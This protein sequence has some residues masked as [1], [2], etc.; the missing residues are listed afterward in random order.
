M[1]RASLL[2]SLVRHALPCAVRVYGNQGTASRTKKQLEAELAA[3]G[4]QLT[5]TT[6]RE[7]I[8]FQAQVF[9]KDVPK[10]L[11]IIADVLQNSAFDA[12][13]V[14]AERANILKE[15]AAASSD[16]KAVCILA[17][18]RFGLGPRSSRTV[19]CCSWD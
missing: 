2:R 13:A 6:G 5:A 17:S 7:N 15:I 4:G 19:T 1:L 8:S 9:Q 14:E 18:R 12:A 10:A 11:E 3:I 16:V